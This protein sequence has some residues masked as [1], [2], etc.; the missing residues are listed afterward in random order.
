MS[1]RH[2]ILKT[3]NNLVL[4]MLSP[5]MIGTGGDGVIID[6]DAALNP[7]CEVRAVPLTTRPL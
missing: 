3:R 1:L 6:Y 2:S 5:I 4:M 7:S